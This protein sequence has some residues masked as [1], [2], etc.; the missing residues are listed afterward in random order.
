MTAVSGCNIRNGEAYWELSGPLPSVRTVSCRA[1]KKTVMKG[2]SVMVRDG[3]K[4]RFFY[5]TKC[6]TGNADPR[7]QEGGA[8]Q[9]RPDYK[10]KT[11]PNVSSLEGPRAVKDPDGR[12]LGREV[13][14]DEAPSVLGHGKWSV[15]SRGYQPHANSLS[16]PVAS[17]SSHSNPPKNK[18]TKSSS[19]LIATNKKD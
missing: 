3:R 15:N 19:S 17:L 2:E 18:K 4:L 13:H 10:L 5:H 7:T 1:C 9:T 8:Y 11:A 12:T 14:K 16:L 6:F